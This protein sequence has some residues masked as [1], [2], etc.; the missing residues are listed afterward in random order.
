M[1]FCIKQQFN[2]LT[3]EECLTLGELCRIA[4]NLYN[5]GLYNVRQYYFEHK[6]FLNDGKNCRLVKTNENHKLL[7]SNIAQQILKKVNEA[8]Q[9]SFDLAK[10]GKDD[11]KAISLAKYLKRSRR[12]KTSVF[13]YNSG[14]GMD[15]T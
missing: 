8:F 14:K 7:N 12:P 11:Y 6:E 9:S 1:Y 2:G 3:K 13:V 10:Q 15:C 5:A 4:K